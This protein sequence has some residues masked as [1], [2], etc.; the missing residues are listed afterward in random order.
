M[1]GN[2]HLGVGGHSPAS[3]LFEMTSHQHSIERVDRDGLAQVAVSSSSHAGQDEYGRSTYDA[4]TVS[5][6]FGLGLHVIGTEM[7]ESSRI[8]SQLVGRG[9][10]QGAFGSSR[11]MLSLED[12]ALGFRADTRSA[13]ARET[14]SDPSGLQASEGTGTV[15]RL[16]KAQSM[17]EVEDEQGRALAGEYHQ[18]IELQ[19]RSYYRARREVM[20]SHTFHIDCVGFMRDTARRLVDR[21]IQASN[22]GHYAGL[23]D[24]MAEE[25]WLDYRLDC[26][27]LWGLGIEALKEELE[28]LMVARLEEARAR[29]SGREF[30]TIE[31]LLFLQTGDELWVDHL[32]HLQDLMLGTRLCAQSHRSATADFLF[33]SVETY[34]RF[35]EG[36]IDTFLPRLVNFTPPDDGIGQAAAVSVAEDVEEILV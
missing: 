15:R 35:R 17:T 2:K 24:K 21:H 33:H 14:K 32:S 7:N 5:L 36:V 26:E 23:F 13:V 28:R 19:T 22:I 3:K 12:R 18:I 34:R 1:G 30:D 8:D 4:Q 16:K 31:K 10:R 11:F 29:H 9:G 20:D 27:G 6:E 25:L